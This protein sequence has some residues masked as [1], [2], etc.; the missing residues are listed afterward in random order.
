MAAS[1]EGSIKSEFPWSKQRVHELIGL[2]EEE[3]VL[4]NGKCKD[5]HNKSQRQAALDRLAAKLNV[6]VNEVN[7]KLMNLRTYYS[8]ELAKVK[9][10]RVRAGG[11]GEVYR[12]Q[13][14]FFDHM[15]LFLSTQVVPR[16]STV[17]E[18]M[19][20]NGD[21]GESDLRKPVIEDSNLAASSNTNKVASAD[22]LQPHKKFKPDLLLEESVSSYRTTSV[23]VPVP[24]PVVVTAAAAPRG[25]DEDDIFGKHVANEL[26]LIG[27]LRAKQ[28]A[29]LQIQNILFEAQFG[30][31]QPPQFMTNFENQ[32]MDTPSDSDCPDNSRRSACT[33]VSRR[34]K[35]MSRLYRN[36]DTTD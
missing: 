3:Q 33:S 34:E 31:S 14:P 23:A 36:H 19:E 15:D 29:K 1:M 27:N 2:Y 6:P 4:W 11:S 25:D 12:S 22:H 17:L 10:S 28:F 24:A 9:K 26:R 30:Y 16:K 35:Q 13:W 32:T 8:K 21:N 7:K 20:V 18:L 5:Y